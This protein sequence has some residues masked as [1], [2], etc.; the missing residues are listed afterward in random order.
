MKNTI[1]DLQ[2]MY[3][4]GFFEYIKNFSY[5]YGLKT[6]LKTLKNHTVDLCLSVWYLF[7]SIG[8]IIFFPIIFPITALVLY[9]ML[10]KT[11]KNLKKETEAQIKQMFPHIQN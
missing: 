5:W 1:K 3:D 9:L 7:Q 4:E 8:L 6:Q 11:I 10:P 2:K